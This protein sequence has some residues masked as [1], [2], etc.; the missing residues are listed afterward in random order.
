MREWAQQVLV[1]K[2]SSERL[3][4]GGRSSFW[5]HN[6]RAHDHLNCLKINRDN[7]LYE[8]RSEKYASACSFSAKLAY[9]W[10]PGSVAPFNPLLRGGEYA[11]RL[12]PRWEAKDPDCAIDDV[13]DDCC[14][15]PEYAALGDVPTVSASENPD[16]DCDRVL[17]GSTAFIANPL[18]P[19]QMCIAPPSHHILRAKH[20]CAS[21]HNIFKQINPFALSTRQC[22]SK[23]CVKFFV[24]CLAPWG[25]CAHVN[26]ERTN[27]TGGHRYGRLKRYNNST[28]MWQHIT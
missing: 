26:G 22:A 3:H 9:T 16:N 11:F 23:I 27:V 15:F 18:C 12:C 4:K 10:L 1:S 17:K 2:M 8:R 14:S 13:R 21:T 5:Y 19:L 24:H 20:K 7:Y 25:S 6:A 28:H